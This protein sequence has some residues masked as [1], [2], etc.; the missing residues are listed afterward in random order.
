MDRFPPDFLFGVATSSHQIEGNN[1]SSDWWAFEQEPGRIENGHRSGRACDF[2]NRYPEDVALMKSLGFQAHRLSIEW[3]R[4]EPERGRYSE[5]AIERYRRIL[6][7]HREAGI[8]T[9]A[10]LHHF[11]LPRWV[12]ESGNLLADG[13][14]RA[15][16]AYAA[17]T[18]RALRGLVD[19]W[20]TINEPTVW[21]YMGFLR[22]EFA[23]GLKSFRTWGKALKAALRAHGLAYHA[24]KAED[25][26][27]PAG[28]VANVPV[29]R[30]DHRWDPGDYL[31]RWLADG[32][33][34]RPVVKALREGVLKVPG[35]PKERAPALE[36][37]S[38]FIGVNYYHRIWTC[39]WRLRNPRFGAP[40]ERL[41]QMG[42]ASYPDGLLEALRRY[43][44]LGK[45]LY[46]TENGVGT[47]DDGWRA[48]FLRDHLARVLQARAEGL[49]VRGYF[50]WSYIDNF[51]WSRGW[52]PRFGL[53]AFDPETLER[54]PKP[55][56]RLYGEVARRREL[57]PTG[58]SPGSADSSR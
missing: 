38:D 27:T 28:I 29:Y 37:S 23:P 57:P 30:P 16:E 52:V 58:F 15:F 31:V 17:R 36:G 3:S 1:A 54:R 46:V 25:P 7:A 56:A 26:H 39:W 33:F 9:F 6:Q 18:V 42:W 11:T 24:A 13:N 41:S 51:E 55:S 35:A 2:W 44:A 5:E 22:G 21:A 45:P 47:E 40:G 43:G 4:V 8:K 14:L 10:T 32:L 49:D 48:E 12:A 19:A 53:V 20:N 50:H 34:N